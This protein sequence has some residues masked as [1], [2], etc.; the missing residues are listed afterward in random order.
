METN[1]SPD[2]ARPIVHWEIVARDPESQAGFYRE[3]FNWEI[4]P[5]P[6]MFIPAGVGGP[7]PGPGGHMRAGE[8]SAV[9]LYVQVRDLDATM[10]RAVELGG[11]VLAPPFALPAGPTIASI[12]DPEGNAIGLVQQ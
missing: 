2:W 9:V 5:G 3:M 12:A 8:Q 7:E 4:G 10:D 6:V 11:A 1:Q